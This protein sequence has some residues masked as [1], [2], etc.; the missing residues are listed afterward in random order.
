MEVRNL[1]TAIVAS[2]FVYHTVVASDAWLTA[3]LDEEAIAGVAASLDGDVYFLDHIAQTI[4]VSSKRDG[5][6]LVIHD[7]LDVAVF[8]LGDSTL[9]Y[10]GNT[11]E[12]FRSVAV[13][14][15]AFARLKSTTYEVDAVGA[16][17]QAGS[18]AFMYLRK[19]GGYTL[20]AMHTGATIARLSDSISS[21]VHKLHYVT[22]SETYRGL[23]RCGDRKV[24]VSIRGP[25]VTTE[26]FSLV[27]T[28]F[29][30]TGKK[31]TALCGPGGVYVCLA[32]DDSTVLQMHPYG[33]LGEP[34]KV[35]EVAGNQI[36]YSV[37]VSEAVLGSSRG[38][39]CVPFKRI[40]N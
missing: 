22:E 38:L 28:G 31:V 3:W 6:R 11:R 1:A 33:N 9:V 13:S 4:Y 2:L 30:L 14:L 17:F 37:S 19:D 39:L 18:R 27:W 15:R 21:M 26:D 40:G 10:M 7:S 34:K 36:L 5:I 23:A 29:A 35:A 12:G 20:A 16:P 32:G 8:D 25:E 24:V